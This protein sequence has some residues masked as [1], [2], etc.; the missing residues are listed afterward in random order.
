ME[1]CHRTA[2]VLWSRFKD[3]EATGGGV[4]VAQR[5]GMYRMWY[6]IQSEILSYKR[7]RMSLTLSIAGNALWWLTIHTKKYI[8]LGDIDGD[9]AAFLI[10][11]ID[12]YSGHPYSNSYMNNYLI[13]TA[14]TWRKLSTKASNMHVHWV[15]VIF[16]LPWIYIWGQI[17][18]LWET[19]SC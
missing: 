11:S 14:K 5:V 12:L 3:Q 8:K 9:T 6:E 18:T 15:W 19:F 16:F 4:S 17:V 2:M 7:G 10:S 1:W 13:R